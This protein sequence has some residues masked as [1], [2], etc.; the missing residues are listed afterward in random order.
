LALN[1]PR[2]AILAVARGNCSFVA[3]G[4]LLAGVSR[5]AIEV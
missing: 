1:V 2:A 3:A 5:K 4:V